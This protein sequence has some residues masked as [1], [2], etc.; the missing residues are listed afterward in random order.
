V[1]LSNDTTRQLTARH[2]LL[3]SILSFR[4]SVV[5]EEHRRVDRRFAKVLPSVSRRARGLGQTFRI[6]QDSILEKL[7]LVR[8]I[9]HRA[10]DF[11]RGFDDRIQI[12]S[13]MFNRDPLKRGI[14]DKCGV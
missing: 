2:V 3:L 4:Q 6:S 9:G 8:D 5:I 11:N 12:E 13:G 1:V 10:E 7:Y 14:G